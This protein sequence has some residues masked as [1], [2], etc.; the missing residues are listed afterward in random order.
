MPFK[1]YY[2][3]LGVPRQA[4]QAGIRARYR[5]LVKRLHPDVA[6]Q[7]STAAFQEVS[8]AYDVLS[9]PRGRREHNR[10]L[11]SREREASPVRDEAPVGHPVTPRASPRYGGPSDTHA[12]YGRPIRAREPLSLHD[13]QTVHP[14]LESL[15][16]RIVRNFTGV[17]VPKS[18]HLEPLNLEI[19]LTPVEAARGSRL[20]LRIPVFRACGACAGTGRDWM[21]VC[22]SCG[23]RG[24]AVEERTIE[25]PIPP[26]RHSPAVLDVPLHE[27]G[28]ANLYLRLHARVSGSDQ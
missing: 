13:F 11:R 3:I 23:G 28:I 19:V 14:S 10:E 8:E 27:L 26:I 12:P 15:L 6:G 9:D 20:P 21:F 24:L 7:G 16:E 22:R 5:D 4:S 18:E 2:L 1:N 25:I 17:G